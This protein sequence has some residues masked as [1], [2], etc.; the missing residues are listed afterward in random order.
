M[1]L[2]LHHV[3]SDITGKTG[4]SIL[5]AIID[6]ERNPQVLAGFRDKRIKANKQTIVK[7]LEGNYLK[8]YLSS[9]KRYIKLYDFY[10]NQ[11][12]DLDREIKEL[13]KT[14]PSLDEFNELRN[15]NKPSKRQKKSC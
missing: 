5:R 6:G 11:L 14:F 7:S 12:E 3:I 4:M 13:L 15:N 10:Q 9:L 2:Q 1:N 8:E